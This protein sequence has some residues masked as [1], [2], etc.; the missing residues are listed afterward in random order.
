MRITDLRGR[1]QALWQRASLPLGTELLALLASLYFALACNGAFWS[2]LTARTATGPAD[3]AHLVFFTG[4]LLVG[5]HWL[6][7]LLVINRW[8]A[9]P[10]L[11]LLFCLTAPAV[12][13]MSKYGV[14]LDKPMVRNIFETDL[15]E[16]SELFD[17]AM[18]P[19]WLGYALLPA[20]VVW[21]VR[22]VRTSLPRA[23]ALRAASLLVAVVMVAAG[24]WPVMN[25][26][27]PTFREH[28]ELRYL[29]TPSNF[30]ISSARLVAAQSVALAGEP[31]QH[32]AI[33]ADAYRG[34]T[35]TG[36]RPR[37][38]VLVIG[39]TVRAANWGLN[40]YARQTT[41]KLAARGLVNFRSDVS[42][43]TD[44]ATSLPCMFSVQGRAHYDEDEIRHSESLL[45]V[46]HR[47]GV[48]VLWRDNQSGCKGVCVGLPVEDVST[49]AD[50]G[51]CD[52]NRC[53]DGILLLGIKERIASAQGETL[54]VLHMLGNHGPAYFQRY[55]ADFRRF[56]PT[57]DTTDLASCSHVALVNTY[58]NA[59]LYTDHVLAALID[60]L[61][62]VETHDTAMIYVSDH[63][64]SLGEK[65]LYLHGVPYA[66][67]P[68]EQTHVPMVMWLS[69]GLAESRRIDLSCL[70]RLAQTETVSHD[71]L[72]HT[73]LGLFDVQTQAYDAGL[74]TMA[75]CRN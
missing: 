12:Y 60:E 15:R 71:Y 38:I 37:A 63:G 73:L 68:D 26:L 13:F 56:T 49:S 69:A 3:T 33:A 20:L 46:L 66:I 24:I 51:F 47:V 50:P 74:D 36:R 43:G 2:A 65:N 72:F 67:A 1:V 32:E 55:P 42:C 41:P 52:G 53:L 28:K 45:H 54:I 62:G 7:L 5:L 29:V 35:T 22:I 48:D 27:V 64:E 9:K 44:T 58:D 25:Q 8:T 10:L 6:L 17:R 61:E 31:G 59:I 18:V 4:L 14:Y 40:G 70:A 23:F 19:Y 16:A 39:E 11:V 21:R 30:V 75:A 34:T 57:C